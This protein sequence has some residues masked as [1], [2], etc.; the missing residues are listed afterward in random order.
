MV[1]VL[2]W[3]ACSAAV[4]AGPDQVPRVYLTDSMA[5]GAVERAILGAQRHLRRPACS[6][7]F[8]DFADGSRNSASAALSATGLQPAEYVVERIWF[9]DGSDAP[10]CRRPGE[11]A[12]FTEA[13]SKVVRVCAARFV[14]LAQRRTAAELLI[15]HEALHTLGVGENPPAS[16]DITSQVTKR[17]GGG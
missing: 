3:G 6:L 9:V 17:C 10:Q 4:A 2:M 16:A 8:G 12:A 15:I 11:T 13:G 7:V 14:T 5:R 1:W